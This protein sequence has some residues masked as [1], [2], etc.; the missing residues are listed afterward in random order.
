MLNYL[1]K[2]QGYE[3]FILDLHMKTKDFTT[4]PQVNHNFQPQDLNFYI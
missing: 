1:S 3:D 4:R 2:L